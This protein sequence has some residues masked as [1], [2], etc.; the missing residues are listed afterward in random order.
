M[1]FRAMPRALPNLPFSGPPN[2]TMVSNQLA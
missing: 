1:I 2:E